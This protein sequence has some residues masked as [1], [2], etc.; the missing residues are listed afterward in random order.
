MHRQ[1]HASS[2]GTPG[3][4]RR[5]V[6]ALFLGSLFLVA[7][8]GAGTP[9]ADGV[10]TLA[11]AAPIVD[12]AAPTIRPSLS[13][14]DREEA[15]LQFAAC[16]RDGGVDMPDPQFT[17]DGRANMG[18]LFG[19][20]DQNDPEVKAALTAC[21]QY[22]PSSTQSDPAAVAEQQ[23]RLLVF[24]ACM[25]DEGIEMADPVAGGGPGRGALA[26]LDQNDPEIAAAL[27]VCRPLLG[28]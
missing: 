3:D 14:E 11:T 27:E 21:D 6:G 23:E 13:P 20:I 17:A 22:L 16:M 18:T 10:A 8:C 25:R 12:G 15:L 24:A 9:P 5:R 2:T 1:P 4:A 26:G 28:R 19:D 7:A